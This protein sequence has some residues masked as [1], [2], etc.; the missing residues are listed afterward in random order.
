MKVSVCIATYN[1]EK[2][3]KDQLDSILDQLDDYD[4]VIISDDSSTDNTLNIIKSIN[5]KRIKIFSNQKFKSPTYNFENA[6]S[7]ASGEVIFLADQD[8]VWMENK[9]MKVKEKLLFYDVVVTNCIIVDRD[10]NMINNSFYKFNN[11]GKGILKNIYKNSYL[12]CCLAFK[13]KTLE[14]ALPFPEKIPMHDIWLGFVFGLF[15]NTSFIVEPLVYYRRH[16]SNASSTGEKSPYNFFKKI[17]F[18]YYI[19]KNLPK[20][21]CRKIKLNFK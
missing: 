7:Q 1:G 20:L 3:I 14:L 18:R 13:K 5:D 17:L 21:I 6:I 19:L 15:Y 2:Y 8:D 4:E 11:S 16:G 12:G 9:I 10:L